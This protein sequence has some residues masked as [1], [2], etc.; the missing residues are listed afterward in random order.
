VLDH[1]R[2]ALIE[3]PVGRTKGEMT[4]GTIPSRTSVKPKTVCASAMTMS[5]QATSPLPPPSA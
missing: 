3:V 1:R 4:A 5:E 2:D